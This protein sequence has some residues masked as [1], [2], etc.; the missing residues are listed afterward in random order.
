MKI[1]RSCLSAGLLVM[2]LLCVAALAPAPTLA[3]EK[4]GPLTGKKIGLI[5]GPE[6]SDFQAYYLLE[7]LSEL[8]A[9]VENIVIAWPGV[10]WKYTRPNLATKGV[11]GTFG[12]SLDPVSV[13]EDGD[14]YTA[15]T[16]TAK[17]K[18]TPA[19]ARRYDALVILGGHSADVIRT[20]EPVLEFVKAAWDNGAIIGGI[21]AGPMVLMSAGLVRDRHATGHKVIRPFLKAQATYEDVPVVR[22][23]RL[24]TARDTEATPEFVREL[25]KAFDPSYVDPNKDILRG[26]RVVLIAGQD[27]EDVELAVPAME[28]MWRGAE[29]ILGTFPPPLVARPPMIGLDVVMGNIGISVPFQEIRDES[30]TI[31]PL[32][33]LSLRDYDALMIPGGFCPWNIIEDG[34]GVELVKEAYKAGKVVAAVCHGPLVFAAAD[35]VR[36]KK[37]AG[38]L[39]VK[40]DVTTMGGIYSYDWPA[41]IDGNLVTGR[42]PDDVP[43]FIDALTEA[44]LKQSPDVT[45]GQ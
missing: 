15:T 38:W 11:R 6:F 27:F 44:I 5:A 40:D 21:G 4:E 24:I 26:R 33:D 29:V 14:R 35:I 17:K 36:G 16:Y 7:Y 39:A 22:D 10:R 28:L 42:V 9:K 41:M 37:I 34:K 3:R 19:K 13:M 20:E 31:A 45:V 18:L 2:I 43:E 23:G 8:G 30:Y 32:K 1:Y 12:M 25:A